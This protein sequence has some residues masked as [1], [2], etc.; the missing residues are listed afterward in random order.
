MEKQQDKK[1]L[2][3]DHKQ[4]KNYGYSKGAVS[5]N[6]NI[7]VDIKQDLKDAIECAEE[8]IREAK[9]DLAKVK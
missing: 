6:Y 4:I 1:V 5:F 9:E 2:T 7:R 8:F 3:K